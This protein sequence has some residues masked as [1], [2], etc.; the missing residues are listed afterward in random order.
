MTIDFNPYNS[1]IRKSDQDTENTF[2]RIRDIMNKRIKL[3]T[4]L[5]TLEEQLREQSL[6]SNQSPDQEALD[7]VEPFCVDTLKFEEWLQFIFIPRLNELISTDSMLPSQCSTAPMASEAWKHQ[8]GSLAKLVETLNQID[9][10]L[11]TE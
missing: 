2:N 1:H 7:S 10:L 3:A 9:K 6:W 8:S 4:L 11:S 5:L